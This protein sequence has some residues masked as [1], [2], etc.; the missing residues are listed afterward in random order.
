MRYQHLCE[1]M[2]V[3][4]RLVARSGA[5]ITYQEL[6]SALGLVPPNTIHQVTTTLEHLMAQDVTDGHPLIAALVVRK[7]IVGLPALGFFECAARLGR[8]YGDPTRP[9]AAKFFH[10]AFAAAVAHWG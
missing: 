5:P 10:T 1:P 2:R 6:A 7:G 8:F 9:E 4:L 3:H